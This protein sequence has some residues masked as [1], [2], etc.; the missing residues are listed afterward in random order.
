[1]ECGQHWAASTGTMAME[2]TVRFLRATG[3]V[4]PDFWADRAGPAPAAQRVIEVTDRVTIETDAFSF[5]E[6]FRGFEIIETAG[7][8]LARDGARN[9]VT[10][11]DECVLIMPSKRLWPGQ[12]AVRLGRFIDRGV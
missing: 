3:A 10:P 7:T 8:L 11:Y 9:V 12:T 1:M 4:A 5:V 2:T 6:P